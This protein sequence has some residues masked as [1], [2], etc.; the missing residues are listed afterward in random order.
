[1]VFVNIGDSNY[2][3]IKMINYIEA[4][5]RRVNDPAERR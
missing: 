1:M 3:P 4:F 5:Q 2:D